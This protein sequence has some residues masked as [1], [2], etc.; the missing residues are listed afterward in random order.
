MSVKTLRYYSDIGLLPPVQ[1][2]PWTGY[3]LYTTSQLS[4]L[5]RILALRQAGLSIDE[6][7]QL[8]SGRDQ[9]SLLARR[10]E[11]LVA[12]HADLTLQL[13]RLDHYIEVLS[14]G[15]MKYHITIKKIPAMTVFSARKVIPDFA[16]LNTVF[17]EVGAQI[18]SDNPQLHCPDPGYCFAAFHDLEFT[19]Q[20]IDIEICQEVDRAGNAGVGYVF[21]DL[22]ATTVASTVHVGSFDAVGTAY[23][24]LYEWIEANG[25]HPSGSIRESYIDG[26][27][28]KDDE[29]DYV[30]E[31]QVPLVDSPDRPS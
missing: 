26:P 5:Q 9:T 2:D 21:K 19:E 13:S 22:P 4:D 18:R 23:T 11:E 16:A 1:I 30:T 24:A 29:A 7:V 25:H 31:I 28:N 27:W 6:I 17:C 15:A 12:K 3:R 20:N 14:E 10:R 8:G